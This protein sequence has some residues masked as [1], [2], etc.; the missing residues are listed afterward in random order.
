MK[1]R[2][3]LCLSFDICVTAQ[4]TDLTP[5]EEALLRL[6]SVFDLDDHGRAD[7]HGENV[8]HHLEQAIAWALMT[9]NTPMGAI[10]ASLQPMPAQGKCIE[11]LVTVDCFLTTGEG[12]K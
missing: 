2:Y 6:Q 9:R 11:P 10:R 7:M 5:D 3:K 1:R 12:E 4:T 8:M